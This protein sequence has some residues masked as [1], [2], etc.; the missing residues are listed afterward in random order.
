[1]SLFCLIFVS[2]NEQEA[3][4]HFM[5]KSYEKLTIIFKWKIPNGQDLSNSDRDYLFVMWKVFWS[6]ELDFM[7]KDPLI[8]HEVIQTE[9]F[10]YMDNMAVKPPESDPGTVFDPKETKTP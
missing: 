1:M 10:K 6:G 4:N 3:F 5:A 8:K 9:L 7:S 2:M